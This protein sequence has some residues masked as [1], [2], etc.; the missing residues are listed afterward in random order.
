MS[1]TLL[2]GSTIGVL[3]GGQLGRMLTSEAQR[4]G[5]RVVSWIGG[6]DS[7]PAATAD[8]IIEEPFNSEAGLARFIEMADVATVEFENIPRKLLEKV[9]GALPLMPGVLAIAT[10]QHREREKLFLSGNG[11]PCAAFQVVDS[12]ET[13]AEALTRLPE[14]GG[15]LKTAEFGYDG[16]GQLPVTSASNPEE[17][18]SGFGAPRAVLEEKVDLAAELSVLVVRDQEGRT[19][20]YDPCENIHRDHI[21]D[22]TIVPARVGEAVVKE[23]RQVSLGIAEALEYVGILAVEFFVS[24]DGRLIV[25]EM[26][27]RPHNSGHHTID[28][29]EVS[30]FEQ[31]LRA[32][33]GLP[34]GSTRA[35]SPTVMLNLL[36]DVWCETDAPPDW[37]N[38]LNMPGATLHLYGKHEARRGRKMGHVTFTAPTLE[39]ALANQNRAREILGIP[40]L[41]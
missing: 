10:C 40:V 14:N 19:V 37:S 20:C 5:Y 4:M 7:G 26:A 33:T 39:E 16:K 18:W 34:V 15:I 21:L 30:Q 17:T 1:Q 28:A 24:Y 12:A 23:A 8:F 3:G 6:A 13:L 2:P 9:A 41:P 32:I 31:Q 29:N 36:G 25:N 11:F 27:P 22:V 35:H 38:V